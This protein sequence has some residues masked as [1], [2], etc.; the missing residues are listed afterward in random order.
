M[1]TPLT[2]GYIVMF[3]NEPHVRVES[4]VYGTLVIQ[5][6][7]ESIQLLNESSSTDKVSGTINRLCVYVV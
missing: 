1:K 4:K 2:N 5:L 7:P 3:E 6:D